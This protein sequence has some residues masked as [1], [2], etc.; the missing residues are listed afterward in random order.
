GGEQ[1]DADRVAE[2]VPEERVGERRGVVFE[3]DEVALTLE[4]MPVVER[5][6]DR[7]DDRERAEDREQD[8]ERCDVQVGGELVVPVRE[9][10]AERQAAAEG[11]PPSRNCAHRRAYLVWSGVEGGERSPVGG[12]GD[13]SVVVTA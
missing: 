12:A 6:V 5:D 13:R 8:E 1:E 10:L 4:Q 3:A 9:L 2:G 7:V 11:P